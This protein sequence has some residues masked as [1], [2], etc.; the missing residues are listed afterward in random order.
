MVWT[1]L[2][3]GS[4][5]DCM[6]SDPT[7]LTKQDWLDALDRAEADIADGRVVPAQEALV[8]I[9]KALEDMRRQSDKPA[10]IRQR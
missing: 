4:R 3:V 8:N 7:R 1:S 6:N 2:F 9:D 10:V 5:F